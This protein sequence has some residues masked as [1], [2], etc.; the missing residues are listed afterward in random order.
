DRDVGRIMD[1]L[2]EL[3]IAENTLV[4]FSSDNGP[5]KEGGADPEFFD[6]NGPLRG[7]KR[8]LYE[9]GIRVPAIAWQPGTVPAGS[10]SPLPWAFWDFMP[11]AAEAAGVEAPEGIDGIS[12]FPTICGRFGEQRRHEHLYW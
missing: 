7:I 4:I 8:D 3:A 12:I 11:T 9:G 6:S 5:H 2:R 10:V 1:L